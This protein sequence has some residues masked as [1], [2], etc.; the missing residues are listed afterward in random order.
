MQVPHMLM[1]HKK[2]HQLSHPPPHHGQLPWPK[3]I[4][5]SSK[6]PPNTMMVGRRH[7]YSVMYSLLMPIGRCLTS[8]TSQVVNWQSET[9][10]SVSVKCIPRWKWKTSQQGLVMPCVLRLWLQQQKQRWLL[11]RQD[12]RGESATKNH[13]ARLAHVLLL[14]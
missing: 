5:K 12:R 1:Y 13:T 10:G 11:W 6:T 14:T 9:F 7:W 2:K 3:L 4:V 8:S